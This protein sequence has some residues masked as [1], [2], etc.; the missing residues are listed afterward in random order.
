MTLILFELLHKGVILIAI[1]PFISYM[2]NSS[3]KSAN[4]VYLSTD[5]ITKILTNPISIILILIMILGLAF[6]V[7]FELTSIIICFDKSIKFSKIGLLELIKESLKRSTRIIYAKN[8]VL[9]AFV[10]FILPLTN[11]VLTSGFI[12]KIKMPE[13]IVEYIYSNNILNALYLILMLGIYIL[14]IR[15]I[16]SIHEITLNTDSFKEAREKSILLTKGKNFKIFIYST[17]LFILTAIIGYI[18]SYGI[19]ILIG[20]LTKHYIG[21]IDYAKNIFISR[22]MRFKDYVIFMS[23]VVQFILSIGFL[24][25]LYYEY[26]NIHGYDL[27]EIEHKKTKYS[28]IKNIFRL[29]IIFLGI[30]I[31][32]FTFSLNIDSPF[33]TEFLYNT[34]ATGHRASSTIAP[35]NT[36]AAL[37]EAIISEAEYAEIDVQETKDGELIISHD[38][39]FK[40]TTGIDKNVWEV[41]YDEVKTYDAGSYFSVDFKGEKI[42]TLEEVIKNSKGKIK[43]LIEIKASEHENDIEQKVIDLIKKNNF[44][45]QCVIASMNKDVLQK[46]KKI[47]LN[48]K[49]CYISAIAYGNFYDWDYVNVYSIESTFVNKNIIDKIHNSGKQ[50]FV[51]TINDKNLMKK[52]I[53][54]NVDSIITDNPFL[55]NDVIY[56]NKNGFVNRVAD[57]LFN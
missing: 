12:G 5:N 57:Y 30:C 4:I 48:L 25:A 38:S 6:Y 54:L 52:M 47:D 16:F 3:M 11:L 2:L 14:A 46:I 20:L 55:V 24:S 35:E 50:I 45:N 23:S 19:I 21:N 44:E 29:V 53:D 13:Y 39:N 43:L 42:P 27:K 18:V 1:V 36:L 32:S 8:I 17:G 41:D 33:N 51:W 56:R 15:W 31:E 28:I 10:I 7:F 26:N 34:T 37:K 40:R 49:T 22:T 9:I